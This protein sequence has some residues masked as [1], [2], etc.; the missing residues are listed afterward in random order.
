MNE[1][2]IFQGLKEC[3]AFRKQ[4]VNTFLDIANVNFAPENVEPLLARY[5]LDMTWLESFFLKRFDYIVE[6]LGE[7]FSL[8]G[9]LE[10]VT[11]EV[12]DS[13]GGQIFLNT[14]TP[15]VSDGS[16]SGRYYTDFP[17]TVTAQPAEGYRFVGWEGSY[18][19]SEGTME[20]PVTEGGIILK[21]IFEKM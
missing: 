12:N 3:E 6:D 9:T 5:G 17:I 16:W 13:E 14:T 20:V 2:S 7:E 8:T 19:G 11:L 21:A 18:E 15:D 10:E 4:F 1:N